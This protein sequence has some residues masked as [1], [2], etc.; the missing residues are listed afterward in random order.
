MIAGA[1]IQAVQSSANPDLLDI[2]YRIAFVGMATVFSGLVILSL[3]LPMIRRM[4]EGKPKKAAVVSDGETC[5]LTR[6]EVVAITAAVHAHMTQI[7]RLA[8]MQ[9]TWQM[10]ERPYSP[11]RL[12]GRAKVLTDRAAFRQRNRSR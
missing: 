3:S 12:A 11:W 8:V 1:L 2:G 6:E 9:L 7:T 4:A 10:Y 5:E